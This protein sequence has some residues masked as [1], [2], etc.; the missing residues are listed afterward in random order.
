MPLNVRNRSSSTSLPLTFRSVRACARDMDQKDD[1]NCRK[2]CHFG[3]GFQFF[4]Q[5]TDFSQTLLCLDETLPVIGK[6]N[7]GIISRSGELLLLSIMNK[8]CSVFAAKCD[9]MRCDVPLSPGSALTKIWFCILRDLVCGFLR[10]KTG[11]LPL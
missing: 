3:S 1:R 2:Q 11:S 10:G 9:G 6:L 8:S 5:R 7:Y 4:L